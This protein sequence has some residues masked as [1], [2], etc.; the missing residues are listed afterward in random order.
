[1]TKEDLKKQLRDMGL[2]A[3]DSV[4]IHSSMKAIGDVEGGADTVVDA[5]LEYFSEGLV[6]VPTH[7]WKQMS[8]DYN[9]FDPKTEPACVGI[10][11]NIFMKRKGVVR[12]LHPTHSI[13]AYG[14]GANVYISGEE[15]ISTPCAPEGCWGRLKTINAKILLIGVTHIRNTYI[16]AIEEMLD[17]PERF[18]KNPVRF[19]IKMPDS[20]LKPTDVYRH[21]N[22]TTDHISESFD[23][24]LEGYEATDAVKRTKFGFAE[25]FLCDAVKMYNTTEKVLKNEINAFINME[26]I[27]KSWYL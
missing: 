18:T 10:I 27:P 5:L 22:S 25:T 26:S 6:M 3:T 12:S 19:Y 23:K 14:K 20:T 15:N 7:T 1:M 21:Y 9:I 8:A 4:M 11:P 17:V 2:L 24:L 16:H 13:A